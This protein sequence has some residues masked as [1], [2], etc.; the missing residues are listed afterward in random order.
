M[1]V[2][3]V[4][5]VLIGIVT[6]VI[7]AILIATTAHLVT[8]LAAGAQVNLLVKSIAWALGQL[9]AI[10]SFWFGG[11]WLGG[12]ILAGADWRVI[13]PYYMGSLSIVFVPFMIYLLALLVKRIANILNRQL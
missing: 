6:T 3:I 2:G 13:L 10:P 8:L 9:V 5:G 7:G 12:R 11:P 1:V 4:L